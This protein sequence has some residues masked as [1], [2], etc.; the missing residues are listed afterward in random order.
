[1]KNIKPAQYRAMVRK[2]RAREEDDPEK[3]TQFILHGIEVPP[4]KISRFESR[5]GR[6]RG[7]NGR[8]GDAREFVSNPL[9]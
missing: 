8:Q 5:E 7:I 3:A 1:M 6:N 2:K 4:N 9:L